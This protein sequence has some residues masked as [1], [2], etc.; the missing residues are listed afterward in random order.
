VVQDP[1]AEPWFDPTV[2]LPTADPDEDPETQWSEYE[3]AT[4]GCK[5]RRL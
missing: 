4:Y 5:R 3:M 2:P 1:D